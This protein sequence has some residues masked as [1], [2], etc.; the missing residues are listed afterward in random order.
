MGFSGRLEGIAP[1]DIFQII[2]QSRM[3]GTLIAR[4]QEGTAMVVFKDG[5]VIEAASDA[6]HESLASLLVSQGIV[7]ERT[8]E[9]AEHQLKKQA[10]Q[11]LGATLVDMEAISEKTLEAVVLK[12]IAHIIQRLVLC[13]D[14]F[15]T[16]DRGET[17]VRRKIN[18][19]EFL[20][21]LGVST[22]YLIMENARV[23]DE[24]RRSGMDRRDLAEAPL[25]KDGSQQDAAL[26]VK[27][28]GRSGARVHA[29][30]L[31]FRGLR[32]LKIAGLRSFAGSVVQKGKEIAKAARAL[33][34]RAIV[35]RFANAVNRA[36]AVSPDGRSLIYG[37]AAGIATGI[38]LILLIM[39][40]SQ[41]STS[42]LVITGRVV[43]I[44]ATPAI[45]AKVVVKI[46]RGETVSLLS[47]AQGW[48][49]VRTSVGVTGWIW[50]KLAKRKGSTGRGILY[51]MTGAGFVL[52]AGL[53]L[54]VTGIIRKRRYGMRE[55]VDAL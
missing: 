1:S 31:W 42:D 48:H 54:L 11:L 18:T 36:R 53:A 51:G 12:Q 45:K 49:Q 19:R 55:R 5:Q 40:I 16:F 8:I 9:A 13:E 28:Q 52:V 32:L 47:S 3:T 6:Q 43:N 22:E 33:F 4:C 23:V 25:P 21:P 39:R 35:P 24:E 41:P 2:S 46:D 50:G 34:Q 26:P 14:G 17:A 38:V 29:L 15:I 27:E 30:F 7:S 37:G 44:R 20:F 10:D